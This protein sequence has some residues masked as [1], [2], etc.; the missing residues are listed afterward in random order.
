MQFNRLSIIKAKCNFCT[1]NDSSSLHSTE[2]VFP[3]AIMILLVLS[4]CASLIAFALVFISP[5]RA[6]LAVEWL[7]FAQTSSLA[8]Y[9]KQRKIACGAV[10]QQ[11]A[12]K[13]KRAF[14]PS[15][16]QDLNQVPCSAHCAPFHQTGNLQFNFIL[17][18]FVVLYFNSLC[19]LF[20]VYSLPF[21]V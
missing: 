7:F 9:R 17:F 15:V 6:L 14:A 4:S 2:V 16:F 19:L 12:V 5:F 18:H 21:L 1:G 3:L 20:L 8:Y 13:L 10:L 11:Q